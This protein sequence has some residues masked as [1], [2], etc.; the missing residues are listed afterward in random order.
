MLKMTNKEMLEMRMNGATLQE[1]ADVD[2]ITKQAVQKRLKLYAK[3]LTGIRGQGF[4]ISTI[5]YQGVYE[6]FKTNLEESLHSFCLKLCGDGNYSNI[7]TM[8][9]FLTGKSESRFNIAQIKRMCEICGKPFEE[10]FKEREN[11]A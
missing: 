5:R 2:G 11:N 7:A 10:V 4:D 6:Y 9:N 8:R 1:I 3:R